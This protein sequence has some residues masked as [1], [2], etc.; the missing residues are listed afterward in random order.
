MVFLKNSFALDIANMRKSK[1]LYYY[2]FLGEKE[3]YVR[4]VFIGEVA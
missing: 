1:N 2:K 4:L 3:S